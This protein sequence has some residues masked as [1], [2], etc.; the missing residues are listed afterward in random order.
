MPPQN[1]FPWQRDKKK[2]KKAITP[3]QLMLD[4]KNFFKDAEYPSSY[5]QYLISV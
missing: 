1:A 4:A 3:Q 2:K 5:P